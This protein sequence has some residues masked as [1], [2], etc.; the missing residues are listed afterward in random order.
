MLGQQRSLPDKFSLYFRVDESN[1]ADPDASAVNVPMRPSTGLMSAGLMVAAR[2][3]HIEDHQFGVR[4]K[5]PLGFCTSG[6]G[7]PNDRTQMFHLSQVSQVLKANSCD[8]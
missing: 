5:P 8:A 4:K 1:Q 6:F 2:A 7:R 3:K